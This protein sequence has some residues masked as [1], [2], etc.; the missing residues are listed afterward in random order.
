M[1][2]AH[3]PGPSSPD[4]EEAWEDYMDNCAASEALEDALKNPGGIKTMKD[5]AKEPGLN[6]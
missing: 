3:S 4:D 2:N 6:F 5:F 1:K